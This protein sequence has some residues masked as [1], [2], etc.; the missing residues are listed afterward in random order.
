MTC[1]ICHSI[2]G[3]YARA[4]PT[5]PCPLA[6][7]LRCSICAKYGHTTLRC[8][9]KANVDGVKPLYDEPVLNIIS[10]I[11]DDMIEITDSDAPIRAALLGNGITP[12]TCQEKGK[13]IQRDFIENKKRLNQF[14]KTIGLTLVL[15]KPKKIYLD[16]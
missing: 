9:R 10:P 8:G 11:Q 2:L 16:E 5:T 6:K 4:H 14:Y 7:A 15:M 3:K 12:M 13:K 1:N